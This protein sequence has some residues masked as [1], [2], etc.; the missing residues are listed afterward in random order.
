MYNIVKIVFL[1]VI[2]SYITGYLI[3]NYEHEYRPVYWR[4]S[5]VTP[6]QIF[7][8]T[9]IFPILNIIRIAYNF[10][11]ICLHIFTGLCTNVTYF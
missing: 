3:T 9:V 8:D 4:P 10:I 1:A 2:I 6:N 7:I 11:V 5:H